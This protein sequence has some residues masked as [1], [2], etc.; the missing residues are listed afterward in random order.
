MEIQEQA[1]Y[2]LETLQNSHGVKRKILAAGI[3]HLEIFVWHFRH[4]G[5][6]LRII[7]PMHKRSGLES[8][9]LVFF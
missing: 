9:V 7:E 2:N 8:N 1:A 5:K 3:K 4:H 6:V